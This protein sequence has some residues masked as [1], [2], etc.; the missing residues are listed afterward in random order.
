MTANTFFMLTL[1]TIP[2]HGQC[3][4]D[5]GATFQNASARLDFNLQT[6][7]YSLAMPPS[8]PASVSAAHAA[9][10]SWA[11]SDAVYQRRVVEQTDRRMRVEC[12]GAGVPTLLLEF[13]LHPAFVELRAGLQNT[14]ATPIRIK[15]FEPLSGGILF[16]GDNWTDVR[17]LNSPSG[18]GQTQ[19]MGDVVRSSANNL[20]LT[21]KQDGKRRSMVMGD[22]KA[23]GLDPV[24]TT[25][26]A[27]A[28]GNI[29]RE[30]LFAADADIPVE[31]NNGWLLIPPNTTATVNVPTNNAEAVTESGKAASESEGV[32]F[33][34]ME[35]SAAVYA[36]GSGCYQFNSNN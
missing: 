7:C 34:R 23:L 21:F 31:P 32:K 19:V 36:I 35:N 18:A 27:P 16:P 9:I 11:S 22:W 10:E 5:A 20:L 17:T 24:K 8:A 28:S 2:L 33:R 26:W 1:I 14:T 13:T 25:Q 6:G 3:A 15:K 29:Q 12:V 30:E 4:S